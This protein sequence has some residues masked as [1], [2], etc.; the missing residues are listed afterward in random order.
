MTKELSF[1]IHFYS[2]SKAHYSIEIKDGNF[3]Q[4]ERLELLLIGCYALDGLENFNAMFPDV[5]IL[6]KQYAINQLFKYIDDYD[7]LKENN[8]FKLPSFF[9]YSGRIGNKIIEIKI[10]QNEDNSKAFIISDKR[11]GVFSR[12]EKLLDYKS[13]GF[14]ALLYMYLSKYINNHAYLKKLISLSGLCV[15]PVLIPAL[16]GAFYEQGY[17]LDNV[18]TATMLLDTID[19]QLAL[20]NILNTFKII[21]NGDNE[22]EDEE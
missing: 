10:T 13:T 4:D 22:T 16:M 1:A 8:L 3:G 14:E 19:D 17:E 18:T 12:K 7:K 2:D 21:G 11:F 20:S 15:N 6:R 9:Q 5:Y